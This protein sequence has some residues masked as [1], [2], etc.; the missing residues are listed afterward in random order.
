[1]NNPTAAQ[2]YFQGNRMY[3]HRVARQNKWRSSA[4]KIIT[5]GL[6]LARSW[7]NFL[8]YAKEV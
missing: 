5:S 1:M 4:L 3:S 7:S 2:I 8:D 6:N